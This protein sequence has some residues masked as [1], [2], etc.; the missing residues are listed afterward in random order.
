[1]DKK[2][3]AIL[4]WYRDINYGTALQACALYHIVEALGYD[5]AI[6]QY[7]PR[8]GFTERPENEAA[9][10]IKKAITKL[11]NYLSKSYV[12]EERQQL[13][14]D[15]LDEK[16]RETGSVNSG[17]EL[18][19]LN[20]QFDAFVCGSDQIWS[21]N[22]FDENYFL[23]FVEDPRKKIAYAPSLGR[24][25]FRSAEQ[26]KQVAS[27][28]SSFEHLSV[29]E[30]QSAGLLESVTGKCPKVVLDPTLLMRSSQWDAWLEKQQERLPRGQYI[31]CYFL[32]EP[33]RYENYVQG[34][35]SHLNMPYYVIPVFQKQIEDIHAVPFGVGPEEFV[36]LIRNAAFICTDSF[37]GTAF[38]VN[39]NIPFCVFDRFREQDP[40]SQNMR[41][42]SFLEQV[43]LEKRRVDPKKCCGYERITQCDF[44]EANQKLDFLRKESM[45]YLR[46]S[47]QEAVNTPAAAETERKL[48]ITEHCCGCGA[49]A[50]VCPAKAV[51][52]V[53][54]EL[55]FLQCRIEES[56]CVRCGKC[57]D[58]CPMARV[59]AQPI[60]RAKGLYAVQSCQTDV[61]RRSSSGGVGHELARYVNEQ[62][63]TVC[64]CAYRPESNSAEHILIP[65]ENR[66]NLPLLQGSKYIQSDT[67]R[68]M[69]ALWREEISGPLAFFGTPCQVA[70]VDKLLRKQGRRDD[71]LL[72]DL[73]CLGIPSAHLWER[74][75]QQ[76][77]RKW[78]VGA[79]PEVWFRYKDGHRRERLLR[80]EGNGRVYLRNERKDD[81]YAFF[82]RKLCHMG[83]CYDCPYRERSGADLRLGDY[84][85]ER[86]AED[87]EMHSMV[88]ANTGRGADA[89][90]ELHAMCRLAR[91]EY[92]LMEYWQV[93]HPYNSKTPDQRG[94]ILEKL[95]CSGES[96]HTLRKRY[97]G[98]Y[99]TQERISRCKAA[100]K[101]LLGGRG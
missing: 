71:A 14:R 17:P 50:A 82:R 67:E 89:L 59:T 54:D 20:D 38:S 32:G 60:S 16:V 66:D 96:L 47:L 31:L 88:I 86:F 40:G 70:A 35:A 37:H 39:Y 94:Q 52:I 5:P 23:P 53:R 93:Q 9:Y 56:V 73:I 44:A 101:K 45:T 79:N 49:C 64:G 97:C 87:R 33:R 76:I 80:A 83:A 91:E 28:V 65:V 21:L 29:R 74:H 36:S 98:F 15:F 30:H 41:I 99:D 57:L 2:K 24:L 11:S 68:A 77:D 43:A 13:F 42:T 63:Y 18:K 84:W 92:P 1:M 8:R 62:G 81:F 58:V 95:R 78:G 4:T 7:R 3:I 55:G 51:S 75:L 19:G 90:A 25:D 12:P 85:G 26:K 22:G 69:Q 72:V 48:P 61:R 46:V 100:V 6:I 27:L 10:W 34:L